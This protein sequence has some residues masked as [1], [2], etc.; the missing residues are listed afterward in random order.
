MNFLGHISMGGQVSLYTG[1]FLLLL[2]PEFYQ[3]LRELGTFYHAKAKAVGA[4]EE[5]LVILSKPEAKEHMG[6]QCIPKQS[7][8]TLEAKGLTVHIGQAIRPLLKGLNFTISAGER[9]GVIGSSGAGKSTLMNTLMGFVPFDGELDIAGQSLSDT[10]LSSWRHHIA[11]LGQH[12]LIIH[13]TLYDNISFG[14]SLTWK[15]CLIALERA[16]GMDILDRLPEGLDSQLLEQGANL[17]VG[18]AQR[19]ALARAIA[20][21]VQLLILDEPTASLDSVSEALVL[22]AIKSLPEECTIIT[23]THRLRQL[24]NMDQILMLDKGCIVA[25]G[26]PEVLEQASEPYQAFIHDGRESLDHG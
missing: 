14:R 19:I 21:P 9:V 18:Q 5:I 8:L 25:Q 3:P 15:Q 23:V 26:S 6:Q 24:Q 1:L 7:P 22:D 12:P 2:A 17:S 16:Q 11:W 4:A 20:E 13:G 10:D